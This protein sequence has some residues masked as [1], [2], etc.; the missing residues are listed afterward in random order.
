MIYK[1]KTFILTME[2]FLNKNRRHVILCPGPH[3]INFYVS[4]DSIYLMRQG[5]CFNMMSVY[6]LKKFN[7]R[8]D[9]LTFSAVLRV[10]YCLHLSMII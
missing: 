7:F 6:L 10:S 3:K 9:P 4:E 5:F 2:I 1:K 8:P